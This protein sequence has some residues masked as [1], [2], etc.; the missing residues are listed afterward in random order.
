MAQENLI[1]DERLKT[2]ENV[3]RKQQEIIEKMES[4]AKIRDTFFRIRIAMIVTVGI[5]SIIGAVWYAKII[6]D[7]T[8]QMERIGR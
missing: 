6:N 2:L 8:T 7:V 5:A 1:S 3:L 4:R